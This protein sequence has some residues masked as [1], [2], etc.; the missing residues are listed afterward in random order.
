M[1]V[2]K[3]D[4]FLKVVK[5]RECIGNDVV[6]AR[7]KVNIRVELFNVIEPVNDVVRSGIV[8]FNVEMISMDV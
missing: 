6:F 7:D 5:P 8:S 4:K 3:K 2:L 1:F